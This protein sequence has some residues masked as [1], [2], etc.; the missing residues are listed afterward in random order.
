MFS[1]GFLSLPQFKYKYLYTVVIVRNGET[2]VY[3]HSFERHIMFWTFT[4]NVIGL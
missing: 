1:L 3:W 4:K 2:S